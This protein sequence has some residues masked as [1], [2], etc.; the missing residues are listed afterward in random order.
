MSMNAEPSLTTPPE[1]VVIGYGKFGAA[2]VSLAQAH[3]ILCGA[4]DAERP[5]PDP[6]GVPLQ[7]CSTASFVVLAV[8]VPA[9]RRAAQAIKPWLG[10]HTVVLDVGSVKVEPADILRD[11]YGTEIAWVPAHPLFGP[12]SLAR[13][14][15]PRRVVLCANDTPHAAATSAVCDLF[16]R[17][18]CVVV[19]VDAHTHD[20]KMADSHALA[21]FVA[22]GIV[23]L[24][25]DVDEPLA[26]PSFQAMAT[27]VRTVRE[28]AGHLFDVLQN[29]NPY[30]A[31]MRERYLEVMRRLHDELRNS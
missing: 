15:Q 10:R 17:L 30:A 19:N 8:P 27:T 2:L 29:H 28:D 14:E 24:G 1:L 20:R 25:I 7:A 23:E 18:G 13:G 6:I 3:G 4:W 31:D 16:E 21:F 5:V 9:I 12:A 26:P 11:V 22:R